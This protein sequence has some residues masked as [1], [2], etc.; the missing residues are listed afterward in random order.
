LKVFRMLQAATKVDFTNYK[1]NTI[2]R[3]IGRRMI[4]QRLQSLAEYALYLQENTSE[5]SELFRD[6]LIN[7]TN[8]FRDPEAFAALCRIVGARLADRKSAEPFRVWV[9]GCATG[10]EL[11]SIAIC[12]TEIIQEMNLD[13]RLQLFGTD[14]NEGALEKGRAG[15]YSDDIVEEVS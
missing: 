11:Y 7:V 1:R 5:V 15:I 12:L 13:V 9:P 8:F 4:V 3:R 2:R 10:E 6:L 14:I